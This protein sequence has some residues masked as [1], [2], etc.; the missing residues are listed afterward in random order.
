M[1]AEAVG[2]GMP[3]Q[4]SLEDVAAMAAADENHRYELS[5]EGVLSV[6]P[7]ADPGHAMLVS[8]IFAWLLSN[9]YGP[10]QMAVDCGIDVGGAR[11]PDLTV[12]AKGSPPRCGSSSYAGTAGLLLVVEVLSRGSEVVD[13]IIKKAEYA[14][15]RIPRYWIVER[16]NA[17][18]VRQYVLSADTGGYQLGPAGTR[19]LDH[20]LTVV[21]DIS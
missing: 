18:M 8:R 20:L 9:G 13:R 7:A 10:D 1:G 4:I 15:A 12:W 17:T 6:T 16:D 3:R 14:G 2:A 21:P 5:P 19:S 11:V